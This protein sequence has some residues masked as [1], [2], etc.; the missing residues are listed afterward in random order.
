[1]SLFSHSLKGI[2]TCKTRSQFCLKPFSQALLQKHYDSSNKKHKAGKGGEQKGTLVCFSQFAFSVQY[3][4][5]TYF[6]SR[7]SSQSSRPPKVHGQHPPY[8]PHLAN[9]TPPDLESALAEPLFQHIPSPPYDDAG[10]RIQ[11]TKEQAIPCF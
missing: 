2:Q 6:F 4:N 8:L 5:V 3:L 11:L 9:Q 7:T 1:M 10:F